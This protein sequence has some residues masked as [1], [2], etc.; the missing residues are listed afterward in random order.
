MGRPGD[1]V[2]DGIRHV[3]PDEQGAIFVIEGVQQL[4]AVTRHRLFMARLRSVQRLEVMCICP[5]NFAILVEMK[6]FCG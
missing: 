5:R 2:M 1:H 4:V 3:I 6:H